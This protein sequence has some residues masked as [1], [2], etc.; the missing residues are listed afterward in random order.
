MRVTALVISFLFPMVAYAQPFGFEMGAK[1]STAS[2][3]REIAPFRFAVTAKK[4]HPDFVATTV[5]ATPGQGVCMVIG[6][7]DSYKND[8]FGLRVRETFAK[9]KEQIES[10]YGKSKQYDIVRPGGR[11]EPQYWVWAIELNERSF[12]AEWGP[13]TQAALPN[14]VEDIILSVKSDGH[15]SSF[16]H[17]QFRFTNFA[18]CD[19][20]RKKA[21]AGAF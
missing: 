9:V 17:L 4:S 7:S 15:N 18:A 19:A 10:V 20:E 16:I 2:N 12:Q 6:V 1:V 11:E 14:N 21:Q 13:T 3:A 8:G 5:M